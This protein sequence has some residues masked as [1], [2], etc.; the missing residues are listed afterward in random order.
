MHSSKLKKKKKSDVYVT[1][2]QSSCKV[3][4]DILVLYIVKKRNKA[5]ILKQT[6]QNFRDKVLFINFFLLLSQDVKIS[7]NI[8][9]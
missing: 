4:E 7:Q 5:L 3:L 2:I 8:L 9:L 1:A 6:H